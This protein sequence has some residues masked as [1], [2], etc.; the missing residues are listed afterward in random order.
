MAKHVFM[1]VVNDK[2]SRYDS[3]TWRRTIAIHLDD[4][5]C[6]FERRYDIEVRDLSETVTDI[7]ITDIQAAR[8]AGC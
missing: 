8:E 1:V 7:E 2:E 6:A 5:F 4:R 3:E